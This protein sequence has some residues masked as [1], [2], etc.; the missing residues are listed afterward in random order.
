MK[1]QFIIRFAGKGV[2]PE[3]FTLEDI[4]LLL[5]EL[6][7]AFRD[8]GKTEARLSLVSIKRQSA[9]YEFS[10]PDIATAKT[11][12]FGIVESLST[13]SDKRNSSQRRVHSYFE[14]VNR[15]K[16]CQTVFYAEG[17]KL[18]TYRKKAIPESTSSI[19]KEYA[20]VIG[21]V[22]RAGGT[23]KPSAEIACTDGRKIMAY[24]D[25]TQIKDLGQ[26]LYQNVQIGGYM[27][28]DDATGTAKID[29]IKEIH[30]F[31]RQ[32]IADIFAELREKFGNRLEFNEKVNPVEYQ[33]SIRG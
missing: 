30:P 16:Q 21:R 29:C 17:E 19:F 25:E 9:A 6:K 7:A 23:G 32:G 10:S 15:D 8:F 5:A 24:G 26:R 4:Q 14:R 18:L 20:A 27:S 12:F 33:R 31:E 2:K 22:I 13:P 28:M 3:S 1:P 11:A